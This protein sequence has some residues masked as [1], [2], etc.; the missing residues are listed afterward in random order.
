MGRDSSP[1]DI[2]EVAYDF[3]LG[4]D[5]WLQGLAARAAETCRGNGA[6]VYTFDASLT[7]KV[8]IG[9]HV[10][11]E[12][13]ADFVQ[14]TRALQ[15]VS[16]DEEIDIFYRRG[17]LTGTVSEQLSMEG[18]SL[19]ENE[20]YQQTIAA[21]GY[22]DTW[23]LTASAPDHRGLVIN[24][25]LASPT[26]LTAHERRRWMLIGAH[27]QTAWRIRRTVDDIWSQSSAVLRPDGSVESTDAE[28]HV[29][30]FHSRLTA[31]VQALEHERGRGGVEERLQVWTTLVEGKWSLVH[32]ID[33]DGRRFYLAIPN[34]FEVREI[35][36]LSM[37]ERQ[38]A[39]HVAQG[40]SNKWTAYQLGITTGTVSNLLRSALEKLQL[41]GRPELIWLYNRL[42]RGE[43]L[44]P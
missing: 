17:I 3:R 22:P 28:G 12:I 23:G 13:D 15:D 43:T 31:A 40:D 44:G 38:V 21:L 19:E 10:G 11:A 34:T 7:G 14:S 36:A 29:E 27:L 39:A 4:G 16:N 30:P 37:R 6:S 25:P 35:A 26:I 41:S 1:F 20:A 32:A 33:T 42:N 18:S 5:D 24:S 9:A 2:V 8:D